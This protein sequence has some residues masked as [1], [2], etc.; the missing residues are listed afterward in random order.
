MGMEQA[1]LQLEEAQRREA[2][3]L[4]IIKMLERENRQ[5]KEKQ[6]IMGNDIMANDSYMANINSIARCGSR[7]SATATTGD[8]PTLPVRCFLTY[9]SCVRPNRPHS[10]SFPSVLLCVCQSV[11]YELLTR[12]KRWRK[13]KIGVNVPHGRSNW[14]ANFHLKVKGQADGRSVCRHWANVIFLLVIRV[15]RM[16]EAIASCLAD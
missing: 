1:R 6:R 14:C 2:D 4:Q 16:V 5:W 9:I 15:T 13:T 11:P 7:P 10:G 8:H 12:I 3:Q